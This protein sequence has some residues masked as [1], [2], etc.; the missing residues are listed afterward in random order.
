MFELEQPSEAHLVR[1]FSISGL[2]GVAIA[3]AIGILTLRFPHMAFSRAAVALW[4]SSIAFMADLGGPP[5]PVFIGLIMF[6]GQFILYGLVGL[7]FGLLVNMIRGFVT[8]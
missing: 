3:V 2:V 8:R 5:T 4:P 6:G 7:A 1:W